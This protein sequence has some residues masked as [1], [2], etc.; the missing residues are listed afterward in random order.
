VL[1]KGYILVVLV[2]VISVT[3]F[4][5]MTVFAQ[6]T[7]G[8]VDH[9][10]T[11]YVGEGLKTGDYFSY[12]LCHVNY[13]DCL[14]FQME[15]WIEDEITVGTEQK[16]LTQVVIFDGNK[17]IKGN[18]VLGKIAPEPTSS[19]SNLVPYANAYKIS[20]AWFSA[21]ATADEPKPFSAPSW[22]KIA[23]IGGQ[24]IKPTALET[25]T[26]PAGTYDTIRIE[27]KTGGKISEVWVVDDFPFPV[28]ASTWTQ[29]S[30][31]IAPQEYRFQ[32]LDFKENVISDPFSNITPT[33]PPPE[34]N[35]NIET[36]I[37]GADPPLGIFLID[38]QS[39]RA[40][41]GRTVVTGT[42]QNTKN[43][44]IAGVKIWAGF[45]DNFSQNPLETIIGTTNQD[46]IL[47]FEI[48]TFSIRSETPN[49][50]ISK[51]TVTLLGF[52]SSPFPEP[53][54][55]EISVSTDKASYTTGDVISISGEVKEIL[56]GF[57]V[58]TQVIADNGN[59]V[60]LAQLV[61]NADKTFGLEITS[62]GPLWASSGEYTVKVLYGTEPRTDETTF[63]F[64]AQDTE[65]T[66][67]PAPDIL[68]EI[69][70]QIQDILASIFGLDTR[71]T[72][73]EEKDM[74]LME[75]DTELEERI[76]ELEEKIDIL[77]PPDSDNDGI[78]DSSDDCPDD[79]ENINGF[80]DTD[81]CPDTPPPTSEPTTPVLVS[82]EL[83]SGVYHL[84]WILPPT[85]L[86]TPNG[87]YDIFIDDD[88]TNE[89]HRTNSLE[90]QIDNLDTSKEHCFKIQARW[91]QVG[92][93]ITGNE[94]CVSPESSKAIEI[95]P[96]KLKYE[97]GETIV[98]IGTAKPSQ[99]LEVLIEDPQGNEF[100]WEII[101]LDSSGQVS[102]EIDTIL[103]SLQGTYVLFASQG[104]DTEIVLVGLGELPE[105]KLFAKPDKLNYSAGEI[106]LLD[107]LGPPS[108]TI[109]L[110][111][112]DPS[113]KNKF[114][115]TVILGPDGQSTYELDLNGYSS[116]VYTAVLTRGNSQTSDV[117]SVGLMT[118][119]GEINVRTTKDIYQPGESILVLGDSSKNILLTLELRD[120]NGEVVKTKETFTNKDGVFS[121]SSL[122]IPLDAQIGI[123]TIHAQSGPNFDDV[124][125]TV[126]DID[127]EGMV[128]FVDS[129][130][131]SPGGKIVTLK[132][133]GAAVSQG[134]IITIFSEDNEE[135]IELTIFT[136]GAG[137][138]STIWLV[139]SSVAPGT[140]TIIAKDAFNE[141]QTT[142]TFDVF[143]IGGIDLS[144]AAPV[145]GQDDAP[146][147]IIEF[148]DY[149]CPNCKQWFQEEKS[150][151]TSDYIL[152]G[153]AKLYFV[154]FVWAGDDSLLAA[155][156]S[157]CADDQGKYM[158]YHSTLYNNQGGIQDGWANSDSLKQFAIDLGLDS[159]MFDE[160]LD[161]GKYSD[162][163]SYNTEVATSNGV[164]GT[165]H[166]FIVAPD[167]T[168][169][170]IAGSQPSVVFDA[171]ILSLG[172]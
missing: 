37:E 136:T 34:P 29:V 27:W 67:P 139:D 81:G 3:L 13:K 162:R 64:T 171:I 85:S 144:M 80:E 93:L 45:F 116:G 129:V 90:T 43:F 146:I 87:G 124:E 142:L 79:P 77:L 110:L 132:G 57:L 74:V 156:A 92:D 114:T 138:F 164:E 135:I 106:L 149:Q 165:P 152:T 42:I 2:V 154:D 125:I 103:S 76:A 8:G 102:L 17:I 46:I 143:A 88:D 96:V 33:E 115:D 130:V 109:S 44:P 160:C 75:K 148:G 15:W 126:I 62:G 30:E 73:L 98:F 68:E 60:S 134:V 99:D 167:G 22:G 100:F 41:D 4:S 7:G 16:W 108:A 91:T 54:P 71:V 39:K 120:P 52:N 158:E 83:I 70:S 140:Y 97:P 141:A 137:D 119:S 168:V 151:I 166:F 1:R 24:Q 105:E 53:E 47:P 66:E 107:I 32:L 38:A 86:G 49:L 25:V 5:T 147:T 59:I 118:G 172:F 84:T 128:I 35:T 117:F 104:E 133:F 61:V 40:D 123:W 153:I 20:I 113:D 14:D 150:S 131:P 10:G 159:E 170:Q 145:E 169:K 155:E 21:Y 6:D 121:E 58:T 163:I 127:E 122:R 63:Q 31:G 55:P 72:E 48:G 112:I 95:N 50:D 89:D 65:P 157:Y 18:M 69:L 82:A 23:N 26:V 51:V 101:N 28:K 56:S 11:W 111:I 19:S 161:S 12:E 94:I 9:P 78:P 36:T